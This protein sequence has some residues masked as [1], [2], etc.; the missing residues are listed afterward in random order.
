MRGA[1]TRWLSAT[2]LYSLALTCAGCGD[3]GLFQTTTGAPPTNAT[4]SSAVAPSTTAPPSTTTAASTTSAALPVAALDLAGLGVA[5]FGDEPDTVVAAVQAV[6]GPP[7]SDSGWGPHPYLDDVEYRGVQFGEGLFLWF[8]SDATAYDPAG[9]RHFHAY[10][11]LGPP[12]MLATPDG[13]TVGST[14]GAVRAAYP[15]A[16]LIID[17]LLGHFEYQVHPA[18]TEDFLCFKF[19]LDEPTDATPVELI[20][21]GI[22]CSYADE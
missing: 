15:E 12:P 18:G 6:L 2:L 10:E 7:V 8:T 19:G 14:A 20:G 22:D 5:R 4:P 13:L 1:E 21:A 16:E 17:A 9:A 11:Y 3:D